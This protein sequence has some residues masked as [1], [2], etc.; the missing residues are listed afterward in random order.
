LP[1]PDGLDNVRGAVQLTA[2]AHAIKVE[3]TPDTSGVP[4]E[5]RL[6]WTTP[7]ERAA[8]RAAAIAA[9]R[10]ARTAVVFAW[11]RGAPA[12]GLPGDQDKL[13]EDIAAVNKNVVVVLNVSEPVAMP[14]LSKVKGVLQMWYPGDEGG[15]ATA[16][17][18]LGQDSP[19][20]RL[21]FTWA[22][23]LG[24]Y[25]ANDPAF[26]ERSNKGKDGVAR[27]SEGVDVGYRWFD[28]KG[29]E[30]LFPFGFGKSYT[31][32]A[33]RDLKVARAADGGLDVSFTVRNTGARDS[34]EVPQ[35][36]LG[37]PRIAPLQADFPVHA[38]A[39]FTRVHLAAG[40]EAP[41]AV[42][43]PPRALQYWSV[44]RGGWETAHGEREV[45][46]GPSSRD[47]PLQTVVSA[48]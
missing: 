30:P 12:F 32:F 6:S 35:V 1:T 19:A 41:V 47:L 42:H 34:D 31:T 39:G 17:I 15:R 3:I 13:I 2:G 23:K 38:L 8:D 9:A 20:G 16:R 37:A 5:V 40:A 10:A 24:D 44:V 11:S 48:P 26:P 27:F 43:V 46:V 7:Q 25:A 22:A 14:W 18:L 21:P 36:Y 29:L 4:A 28:R 45:L 33:Y